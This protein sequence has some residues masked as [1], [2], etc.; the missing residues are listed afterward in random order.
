MQVALSSRLFEFEDKGKT[1]DECQR[2]GHNGVN[3]LDVSKIINTFPL[4]SSPVP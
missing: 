1:S 4:I 3:V 2:K